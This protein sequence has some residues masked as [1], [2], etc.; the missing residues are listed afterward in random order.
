MSHS[1]F[2]RRSVGQRPER[3]PA[4][5]DDPHRRRMA[6]FD[7]SFANSGGVFLGD[8]L[9]RRARPSR[10]RALWRR[11]R[12]AGEPKPDGAG[13]HP[14]RRRRADAHRARGRE[15]RLRRRAHRATGNASRHHR[16]RLCRWICRGCL[17]GRGAVYYKGIAPADRRPRVHGQRRPSDVTA[18]PEG[19][20]DSA[21]VSSRCSVRHQTL[22]DVA[23]DA[24]TISYEIL[25]GLGD[26]YHRQYR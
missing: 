17:S 13:R 3:R 15:G 2:G 20:L 8:A 23:R 10:H 21:A 6:R 14:R 24:G 16:S 19:A 22:E 7:V 26:R 4:C 1:G 5:R 12:C 11:L 9:P 25:T 18:L